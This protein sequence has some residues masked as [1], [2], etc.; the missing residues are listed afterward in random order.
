MPARTNSN[1][2]LASLPTSSVIRSRSRVTICEAFATESRGKPVDLAERSTL[3]GASAQTRLLVN[4]TQT[5]VRIRLRFS[6]SPW[7]TTTGLRNPGPEPVGSDRS[8]QYTWP[9]AITIR[10]LRACVALQLL[11]LG[12]AAYQPSRKRGSSLRSR[13]Q[14]RGA[15]CI[16]LPLPYK[17]DCA[18]FS[19]GGTGVPPQSKPYREWR[20]PFSYPKYNRVL[21]RS[22]ATWGES[23]PEDQISVKGTG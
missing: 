6:V 18:I 2:G 12:Q 5:T 21:G 17:S 23:G 16:Q 1:W 4:G 13:L 10:R 3:P 22:Q 14:D 7:T 8:A 19:S 20:S 11:T 15:R 9:W